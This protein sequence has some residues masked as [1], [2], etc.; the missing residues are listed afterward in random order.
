MK[1]EFR[2]DYWF[3]KMS[4]SPPQLTSIVGQV[5]SFTTKS[6]ETLAEVFRASARDVQEHGTVGLLQE[7]A[8]DMCDLVAESVQAV[9]EIW[10][11]ENQSHA[12]CDESSSIHD[13]LGVD[14]TNREPASIPPRPSDVEYEK[15]EDISRK[16][17]SSLDVDIEIVN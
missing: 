4:S 15:T 6:A 7:A 10:Q 16:S 9:K 8:A 11:D 14:S 3:Y 5:S 17:S 12:A 2:V 1:N 13:D